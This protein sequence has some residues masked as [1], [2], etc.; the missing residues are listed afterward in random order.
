MQEETSAPQNELSLREY[1]DILRRRKAILIQAFIVVLAIG[2]VATWLSP[3]WYRAS[4]RILVE[5]KALSVAQYNANDPLSGLFATRT[6]HD[7]ATQIEVLQSPEVVE[8]AFGNAGIARQSVEIHAKQVEETD[9]IEITAESP[10]RASALAMARELP[11]TYATYVLG[12]RKGEIRAALRFAQTRYEEENRKLLAAELRLQRFLEQKKI[13]SIEAERTKKTTRATTADAAVSKAETEVAGA[14]ARLQALV[15]A[16]RAL[17][18]TVRVATTATNPQIEQ[19]QAEIDKQKTERAKL[20][21]LFK[22]TH[23]DVQKIDAQIHDLEARLARLPPTVTTVTVAPNPAVSIYRDKVNDAQAELAQAR[24][25]LQNATAQAAAS[26]GD[27]SRFGALELEQARLERDVAT[28]KDTVLLLAKS[29]E[30]LSLRDQ[31]T[32]D[33]VVTVQPATEAKQVA[34]RPAANL[35]LAAIVGLM[36]GLGMALLQEYLDDR[37]RSPDDAR[38]LTGM[39]ALGYVPLIADESR[40]LLIDTQGGNL[41]ESFRTLRSSVQFATVDLPATSILVTSTIPGEGKSVTAANLAVAMALD[42][43]RAL[44]VDAD[45]RRPMLHHRFGIEP[46]PGLTDVLIGS[47]TLDAALQSGVVPGLRILA[48][49]PIPPNPAELLNSRAMLELNERLKSEADVVIYD[50]PPCLATADAQ[51]LAARVDGVLY[52]M[53]LGETPKRA[54]R[55]AMELLDRAHARLLGVVFNK[56]DTELRRY[57]YGAYGYDGYGAYEDRSDDDEE[58][59]PGR[60]DGRRR[61]SGPRNSNLLP[62]N[63]ARPGAGRRTPARTDREDEDDG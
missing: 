11:R 52:V 12:N 63:E 1:L 57:G 48:A 54:V 46:A 55:H 15:D 20:L 34:P 32:G 58:P 2:A 24:R 44:L 25:A 28:R 47:A 51:V 53:Q 19:T 39:A 6:G 4:A 3:P 22:P 17:P 31:A 62:G 27:L 30:D 14:E 49:G 26:A 38:E 21:V 43:R 37:V 50:S 18:S 56:L 13:G 60:G 36:L 41:L 9:V 8:R 16:A 35:L 59:I 7:V 45:L 10:N 40:R 23:A 29:K 33:P 61:A 5:G 42:G